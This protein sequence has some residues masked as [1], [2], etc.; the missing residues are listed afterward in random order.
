MVLLVQGA[1]EALQ[2]LVAESLSAALAKEMSKC[3]NRI[4]ASHLGTPLWILLSG[5]EHMPWL[6]KDCL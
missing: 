5:A 6:S 3:V 1:E 2:S 4:G